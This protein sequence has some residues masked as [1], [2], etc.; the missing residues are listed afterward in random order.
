MSKKIISAFLALTMLFMTACGD[1]SQADTSKA[2][3]TTTAAEQ[4]NSEADS[5][6]DSEE[7]TTTT[8]ET[9]STT[10]DTTTTTENSTTTTTTK[11]QATTTTKQAVATTKATVKVTAKATTKSTTNASQPSGNYVG[12][13]KLCGKNVTVN[14]SVNLESYR[15]CF[16]CRDAKKCCIC[17]KVCNSSTGVQGYQRLWFCYSCRPDLKP[18]PVKDIKGTDAEARAEAQTVVA[19]TN[20]LRATNGRSQLKTDSRLTEA[21]MARAKELAVRFEHSRP[22]GKTGS[23]IALEYN[24]KACPNGENIMMGYGTGYKDANTIYSV[25]ENST[26]HYNTMLRANNAY[27]GVGVYYVYQNGYKYTYSVQ[28]FCTSV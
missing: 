27:I 12:K 10:S 14:D 23:S 26:G 25:W 17:G 9:T 22:N 21:A 5:S 7:T 11:A 6:S 1:S 19:L 3:T 15:V 4:D 20:K 18:T 2:D 13:C 28:I 24:S 16:S 8:A